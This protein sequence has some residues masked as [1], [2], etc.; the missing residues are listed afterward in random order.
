MSPGPEKGIS[1]DQVIVHSLSLAGIVERGCLRDEVSVVSFRQ[2]L[3]EDVI[4]VS[5]T[6]KG[7]GRVNIILCIK[8]LSTRM[9]R[10]LPSW[11]EGVS[12]YGG[13]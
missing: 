1:H 13:R 4:E 8:Y 10:H 3:M 5:V 12:V 2:G 9:S 7:M 11:R 6:V